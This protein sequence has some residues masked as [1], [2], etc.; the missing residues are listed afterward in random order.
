MQLMFH[1]IHTLCMLS[2]S[3]SITILVSRVLPDVSS[4][5][6]GVRDES[7]AVVTADTG[8]TYSFAV[9]TGKGRYGTY[10]KL[11]DTYNDGITKSESYVIVNKMA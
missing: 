2:S 8:Q 11:D 5:D 1:V 10:Y 7:G 9:E 3:N 4:S 6:S